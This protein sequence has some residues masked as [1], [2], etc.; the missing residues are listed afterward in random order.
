MFVGFA[1]AYAGS[2]TPSGAT[3]VAARS[4]ANPVGAWA[5]TYDLAFVS[6]LTIADDGSIYATGD[7]DTTNASLD[8]F[9]I[10]LH[11]DGSQAWSQTFGGAGWDGGH[12]VAVG[13]DG[14]ICVAGYFQ[15]TVDFD[16]GEDLDERTA[17]GEFD[18][19]V[20]R[21]AGDGTYQGTMIIGGPDGRTT[22]SGIAIDGKGNLIVL[23]G[24]SGTADFDPTDGVDTRT[25]TRI[26]NEDT[27]DVFLT[28]LAP[29]G[30]YLWTR[31]FGGS[32][33]D[34]AIAVRVDGD[35]NIFVYASF[36]GRVDFD[37]GEGEDIHT[38][39]VPDA[40]FVTKLYPDGSYAW[41][42]VLQVMLSGGYDPI[43]VDASGDV[44]IGGSLQGFLGFVDL[45]PTPE[46][47]DVRIA[48]GADDV[49]VSKWHNDG[50]YGW[51]RTFSGTGSGGAFGVA[52]DSDGG[53]VV[54]GVFTNTM[55]FDPGPGVEQ[56]TA[57]ISGNVFL[58]KLNGAGSWVWTRT[59]D[60]S[61][62]EYGQFLAFAADGGLVVAGD[63]YGRVDFDPGCALD[64]RVS[65]S[66]DGYIAKL[67]C[68]PVT[69]DSNADG[70]VNLLDFAALQNC[71]SGSAPTTCNPGCYQ[72]DLDGDDDIDLVDFAVFQPILSGQ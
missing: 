23:G 22:G 11:P 15:L 62:N 6:D 20:S 71:F 34:R 25:A 27:F 35:D 30:S 65:D 44:W 31:T 57:D 33:F 72:F 39:L 48:Q 54:T 21:F 4:C 41:T 61:N 32:G 66:F 16:P 8:V 37:P 29:D 42:R 64:E 55:D 51:T 70:V 36:R 58:T 50:S 9:V 53:V 67:A 3:Y 59:I 40:L 12:G 49:F 46:G 38:A 10:K 56:R 18:A 52:P 17:Q 1:P 60:G 28:K 47:L 5:V 13:P 68:V 45:D 7:T 24:F 14:N 26:S 63:F 19:F 2:E 69:P 43:E